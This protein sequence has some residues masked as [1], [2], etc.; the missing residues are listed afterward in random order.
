MAR[1]KPAASPL[2]LLDDDISRLIIASSFPQSKA[3]AA[4]SALI[5]YVRHCPAIHIT[6]MASDH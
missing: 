1:L 3:P 4:S 6:R 5:Y 2:H